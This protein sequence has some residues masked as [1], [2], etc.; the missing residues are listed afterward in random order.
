MEIQKP[1]IIQHS[2]YKQCFKESDNMINVK[3]C[4][5]G[6]KFA[7]QVDAWSSQQQ[8]YLELNHKISYPYKEQ[9]CISVNLNESI[10]ANS[11]DDRLYID[12]LN[13]KTVSQGGYFAIYI[14]QPGD[15]SMLSATA[16]EPNVGTYN[17]IRMEM[18][19][20]SKMI[21]ITAV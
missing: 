21:H 2:K 17:G 18:M 16:I 19:N 6:R 5:N 8:K 14:S 20:I 3:Q 9:M 11:T 15:L 4:L 12:L 13:N 7:L 10:V 1:Q